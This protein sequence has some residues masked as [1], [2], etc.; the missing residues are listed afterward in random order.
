ME[1]VLKSILEAFT[2]AQKIV[3][4]QPTYSAIGLGGAAIISGLIALGSTIYNRIKDKQENKR[5]NAANMA[6]AQYQATQNEA[7]I[8]K[9]NQYNTP[10]NQMARF[11]A[12]GLNPNLIYGQG[13][14]GNQAS[15][16]KYEAPNVDYRTAPVNLTDVLSQ[17]QDFNMK[18][19]QIENI[20]ANTASTYE[21]NMLRKLEGRR[22]ELA[23]SQEQKLAPYDFNI[24][25]A[26]KLILYR[27]L[28][29]ESAKAATASQTAGLNLKGLEYRVENQ[30]M[31]NVFQQYEE[32]F[33]KM[34][35]TNGD[36]IRVRVMTRLL[37][38]MGFS[39]DDLFNE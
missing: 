2:G 32:Q 39:F 7:L 27:K 1:E 19:A 6:L 36:D 33:R 14:A 13:N 29:Q 34:G 18:Q 35:I 16:A 20:E 23:F 3:G 21:Q 28:E 8:D 17:Y 4:L 9:Q 15:A 12:G 37:S 31:Q 25:A 10:A 30:R 11:G 5:T 26:E 22:G 38:R 24:R